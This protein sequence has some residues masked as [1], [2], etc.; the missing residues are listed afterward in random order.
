MKI[1]NNVNYFIK[2]DSLK[3]I[4]IAM[5]VIGFLL[6]YMGWGYLAYILMSLFIPAGAVLF[7]VGSSGRSSDEDIDEY[8]EV[9]FRDFDTNI[10][11]DKDYAPRI[12]KNSEKT[13]LSGYELREGLMFTKTKKGSVRS[14]EYVR[15][16][17]YMLN[18]GVYLLSGKISL[19]SDEAREDRV[20][21]LGFD[22]IAEVKISEEQ[23][24]FTFR[25]KLFSVKDLRL[26]IELRNGETVS[27][28]IHDDL[29]S[30][31]TAE[32]INRAIEKR[33]DQS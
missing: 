15:S 28:P 23:K 14:S 9:K 27:V 1:K 19:V 3:F 8:I 16:V 22:D 11:L 30:E 5:V 29:R 17:I 2:N 33:A 12:A 32:M 4:G 25:K 13:L 21:E 10:D 31:H 18:D 7:I 24:R 20:Y 26:V 6:Y